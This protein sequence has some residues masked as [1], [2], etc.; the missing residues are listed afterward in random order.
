[1]FKVH[2]TMRR[3]VYLGVDA[4]ATY[5]QLIKVVKNI[6]TLICRDAFF[7]LQLSDRIKVDKTFLIMARSFSITLLGTWYMQIGSGSLFMPLHIMRSTVYMYVCLYI[8]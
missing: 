1:M 7:V 6:S 3:H 4:C 8:V 2:V 5:L